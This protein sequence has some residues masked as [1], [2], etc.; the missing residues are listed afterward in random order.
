[1]R[2]PSPVFEQS[3]PFYN[4]QIRR[5]L[6]P[7]VA[8][9]NV[10]LTPISLTPSVHPASPPSYHELFLTPHRLTNR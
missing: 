6:F 2:E 3:P 5:Q 9:T 10:H 4:P 7:P 1:L 8:R